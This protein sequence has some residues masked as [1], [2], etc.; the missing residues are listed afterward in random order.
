M[1][2]Q[3]QKLNQAGFLLGVELA[4]HP[5]RALEKSSFPFDVSPHLS[6]ATEWGLVKSKAFKSY[7]HLVMTNIAMENHNF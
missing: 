1:N 2:L 4:L 3:H 7:Y 6:W 5:R